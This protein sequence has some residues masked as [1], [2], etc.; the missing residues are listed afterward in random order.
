MSAPNS[1]RRVL[2]PIDDS[3]TAAKGL[4]SA[5]EL[6][7]SLKAQLRVLHVLDPRLS[8]PS[9]GTGVSPEQLLGERRAV[10]TQVLGNALVS[11]QRAGVEAE[12]VLRDDAPSRVSDLIRVSGRLARGPDRHGRRRSPRR[13]PSRP[14]K[15][16][17]NRAA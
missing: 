16:R 3:V 6:A 2:V 17:R 5:I 7:S 4:A 11:A 13:A 12:T 9:A 8:S 1:Y 10:G 15:Q 14:G